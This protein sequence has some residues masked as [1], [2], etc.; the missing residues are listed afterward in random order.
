MTALAIACFDDEA[1]YA[2]ARARLLA[3]DRRIL[4]EWLPY[5]AD[6]LGDGAGQRHVRPVAIAAGVAVAAG[7]FALT[8][9]SAVWAYPF[10]AGGRPPFSWPAFLIAPIEFG[11]LAAAIAGV[12]MLFRNG[13]LTRL[14]HPAFDIAEMPGASQ[15]A[16]VLAIGCDAGADANA[17]I[18]LLAEA[19]AT[20][21]RLVTG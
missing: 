4:G 19:G 15:G 5:A 10:D 7:L 3:A 20:H 1:P 6:A 17:V 2:R 13:G 16:F 11:A 8:V 14:H 12:V 21:S 18:A 9:W